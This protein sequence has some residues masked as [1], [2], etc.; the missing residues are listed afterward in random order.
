MVIEPKNKPQS[1]P[2]AN[3]ESVEILLQDVLEKNDA[4]HLYSQVL[5]L[6]NGADD[7]PPIIFGWKN[8]EAFVNAINTAQGDVPAPPPSLILHPVMNVEDFKVALLNFAKVEGALPPV[9]TTVLPCTLA[10]SH[11]CISNLALFQFH[12][13]TQYIIAHGGADILPIAI[14]FVPRP[15]SNTVDYAVSPHN[16]LFR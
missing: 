1:M 8:V 5:A 15:R 13:W 10:Q 4:K 3:I 2:T 9:E 14:L 7:D 11:Q 6:A 16:T 12:P